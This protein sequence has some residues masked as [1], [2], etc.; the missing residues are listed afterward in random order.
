MAR[1]E[2]DASGEVW[3]EDS[4]GRPRCAT[5]RSEEDTQ[6]SPRSVRSHSSKPVRG[7][8]NRLVLQM[9]ELRANSRGRSDSDSDDGRFSVQPS[10]QCG[11]QHRITQPMRGTVHKLVLQKQ[12][13]EPQ[14]F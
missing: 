6:L 9:R 4:D 8:V 3:H 5:A 7:T 12:G 1:T 2:T 14:R 13:I 11:V 10:K